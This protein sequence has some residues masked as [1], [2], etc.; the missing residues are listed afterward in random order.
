LSA[1]PRWASPII[2]LVW[3]YSPVGSAARLQH[4]EGGAQN[5]LRNIVPWSANHWMLGVGM[6]WPQGWTSRPVPWE[7]R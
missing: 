5:A 2:S 3:Q 4:Q 6:A 7:L 1:K